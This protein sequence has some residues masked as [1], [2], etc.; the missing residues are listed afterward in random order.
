MTA[1]IMIRATR[2]VETRPLQILDRGTIETKI[3]HIRNLVIEV[4]IHPRPYFSHTPRVL[5]TNL[6]EN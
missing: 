3:N 4:A 6:V 1:G 5:Y 2:I